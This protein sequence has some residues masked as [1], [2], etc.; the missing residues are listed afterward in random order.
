MEPQKSCLLGSEESHKICELESSQSK[1][2]ILEKK[3]KEIEA[4]APNRAVGQEN[5]DGSS[6]V[7]AW[8]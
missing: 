4:R 5:W 6:P 7:L 8:H 1:H 3:Q 2:F